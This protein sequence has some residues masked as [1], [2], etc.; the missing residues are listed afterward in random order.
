[1]SERSETHSKLDAEPGVDHGD[2]AV[3]SQPR[4]SVGRAP[5]QGCG[6]APG[7]RGR[8]AVS[9]PWGTEE[10]GFFSDEGVWGQEEEQRRGQE[11]GSPFSPSPVVTVPSTR[12]AVKDV[13]GGGVG[14]RR[15]AGIWCLWGQGG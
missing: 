13:E 8:S 1:M 2:H 10:L 4:P 14:N 5:A 15:L 7:R 6:L 11:R 12:A 3:A 9:S